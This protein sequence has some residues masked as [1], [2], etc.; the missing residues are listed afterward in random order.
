MKSYLK[1]SGSISSI[2]IASNSPNRSCLLR[3]EEANFTFRAA[4][5]QQET[6][7]R[8]NFSY[9]LNVEYICLMILKEAVLTS[10]KI[11]TTLQ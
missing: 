6:Q 1:D 5:E 4:E 3:N 8:L 9:F 11:S 7:F 2:Q 10:N